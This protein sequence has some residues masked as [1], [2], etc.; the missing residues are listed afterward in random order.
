MIE[1]LYLMLFNECIETLEKALE[2]SQNDRICIDDYPHDVR[3]VTLFLLTHRLDDKQTSR[4]QEV[5]KRSGG[6]KD[7]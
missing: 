4:V 1:G 7:E 5:L 6:E 3:I 2:D